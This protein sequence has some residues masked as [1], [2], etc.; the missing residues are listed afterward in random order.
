MSSMV[1]RAVSFLN[2]LPTAQSGPD[3]ANSLAAIAMIQA[4]YVA[5]DLRGN[6][7]PAVPTSQRTFPEMIARRLEAGDI[8]HQEFAAD[9]EA[10]GDMLRRNIDA[11]AHVE[12]ES[13]EHHICGGYEVVYYEP[14]IVS[15]VHAVSEIEELRHVVLAT[16][17]T[18][19]ATR[20]VD[21]LLTS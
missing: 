9:L 3:L 6:I 8:F 7:V 12:W 11:C 21:D 2:Q 16:L 5:V 4:N 19:Q 20:S 14:G 18:A 1:S 10:L 13:D 15:L 17:S